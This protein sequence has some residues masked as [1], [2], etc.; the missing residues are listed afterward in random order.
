MPEI[1]IDRSLIGKEIRVI[2]DD[3]GVK[4][5]KVWSGVLTNVTS[6]FLELTSDGHKSY[7]SLDRVVALM[8]WTGRREP[9]EL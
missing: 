4:Q 6:R 8:E 5:G 1:E 2:F 3:P 9:E 7:V